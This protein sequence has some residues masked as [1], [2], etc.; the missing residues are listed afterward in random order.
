[1]GVPGAATSSVMAATLL[2]MGGWGLWGEQSFS[3]TPILESAPLLDD[4]AFAVQNATAEACESHA[5]Q[6]QS[7]FAQPMA[8]EL[9]TAAASEVTEEATVEVVEAPVIPSVTQPEK[10]V[11]EAAPGP[12][13]GGVLGLS[14]SVL[15]IGVA[16]DILMALGG[17][18]FWRSRKQRSASEESEKQQLA[19]TSAPA[20]P[21]RMAASQPAAAQAP[22]PLQR[23]GGDND[24]P[25]P[26]DVS[27]FSEEDEAVLAN[28]DQN[29]VEEPQ[30]MAHE[31]MP[32]PAK[33]DVA[34]P[35]ADLPTPQL[36]RRSGQ[37][38]EVVE[39]EATEELQQGEAE[40]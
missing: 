21:A 2:A 26:A 29:E 5:V 9:A 3:K 22:S 38:F 7:D 15:C 4:L 39:A 8:T 20:A 14:S 40:V 32:L 25:E 36:K 6:E 27:G 37:G 34:N 30:E 35:V 28:M 31:T 10:A 1:M 11:E 23:H 12:F 13:A 33:G 19:S 24:E 18:A 17:L 16:F